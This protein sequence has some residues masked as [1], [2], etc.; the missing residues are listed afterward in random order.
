MPDSARKI[1]SLPAHASATSTSIAATSSHVMTSKPPWVR[2]RLFTAPRIREL[3]WCE[4]PQ[5]AHLPEL[6]KT[7]PVLII[8]KKN[9]IRGTALVLPTSSE[10]QHD[11]NLFY[12]LTKSIDGG[13]SHVLCDKIM[14][15][16][17]SRFM[18]L[19]EGV[20]RPVRIDQAEFD[21]IMSKVAKILPLD[22]LLNGLRS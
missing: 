10:D 3:H 19:P 7:R 1:L 18:A 17:G 13:V 14:T 21:T 12:T 15:V 4:L 16:A 5:D 11:P 20:Q 6:W 2:P 22:F 9:T 8:S